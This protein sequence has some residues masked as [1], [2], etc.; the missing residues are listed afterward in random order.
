MKE[1]VVLSSTPLMAMAR[2]SRLS[3]ESGRAV[4]YEIFT[5]SMPPSTSWVA[6][7][8]KASTSAVYGCSS[9]STSLGTMGALMEEEHI[10]PRSEVSTASATSMAT[11]SC[12]S[13]VEAPR[14][15]VSTTL[16]S[17]KRGLSA[18]GGSTLNTSRA[19]PAM[20]PSAKASAR[21]A[22]LM[23]PP[24]A[25]LMIRAEGFILAK[26]SRLNMFSVEGVKGMCSEKKSAV[27]RASSKPTSS[28]P[29]ALARSAGA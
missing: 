8:A 18:G 3:K 5:L 7:L 29:T 12:A 25:T 15:G 19:A 24:R 17:A 23:T 10:S 27:A 22:S 13:T 16:S 2:S 21:S 4:S 28:A 6:I 1:L 26:A 9:S 20:V 14:C 11:P